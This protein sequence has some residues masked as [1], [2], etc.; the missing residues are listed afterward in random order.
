MQDLTGLRH[1]CGATEVE[2][3]AFELDHPD[4]H[5]VTALRERHNELLRDHIEST[6]WLAAAE[7]ELAGGQDNRPRLSK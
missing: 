2:L 7:A 3:T 6:R 4:S 5:L 1:R